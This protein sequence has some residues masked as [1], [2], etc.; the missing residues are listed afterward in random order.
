MAFSAFI[1]SGRQRPVVR[2]KA[3][4]RRALEHGQVLGLLGDDRDRLDARRAGADDADPLA[5]EVHRLVGPVAGV[6]HGPRKRVDARE[7]RRLN[8]T[9]NRR[10]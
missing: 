2:R 1:S 9:G 4:V 7:I 6:V 10:P 8:P 5:G 3:E